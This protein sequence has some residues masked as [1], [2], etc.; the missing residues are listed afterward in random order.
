MRNNSAKASIR[1]AES[2]TLPKEV[3]Q[4]D[5]TIYCYLRGLYGLQLARNPLALDHA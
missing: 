4:A 2:E 3:T 1:G 5:S